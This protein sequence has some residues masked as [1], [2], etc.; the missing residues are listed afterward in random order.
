MPRQLQCL[1][2]TMVKAMRLPSI[3]LILGN[4][5]LASDLRHSVAR[6][7]HVPSARVPGGPGVRRVFARSLQAAIRDVEAHPRGRLFRRLIEFGPRREGASEGAEDD[8]SG[9]LSDAECGACVEFVYSHMVNRFKGELAELLA[10]EPCLTLVEQLQHSHRLPDEAQLFWG[11]VIQERAPRHGRQL[12]RWSPFVKGADGLVVRAVCDG[13]R[14]PSLG[15]LG[16]IEVKSMARSTRR[17]LRQVD[18]HLLRLRGGLRLEG[19]TWL[20]SRITVAEPVRVVVV[21]SAWK[22]SRAWRMVQTDS[23]REMVLP[24]AKAPGPTRLQ[25]AGRNTWRIVLNWSEEAL[26]Q[27]AYEMTFWYM[28]EVGRSVYTGRPLPDTRADMSP[29]EAGYNAI[30]EA[31]YYMMLRPLSPRHDRLATRLY[32]VYS[33]GYPLG[34]DSREMLWPSDFPDEPPS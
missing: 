12:L 22:L 4:R 26:N 2:G 20:P 5:Q 15:V 10:L 18:A 9:A 7:L 23:G 16:A 14:P 29:E 19:E 27:A 21:P 1:F 31:L 30:K 34:A 32:N 13:P 33:F 8:D 28:S 3:G 6:M 11:D 24:D 17:V 25:E